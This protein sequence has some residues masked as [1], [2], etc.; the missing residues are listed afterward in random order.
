MKLPRIIDEW[1][2]VIKRA[3]DF[4]HIVGNA[5]S[6]SEILDCGANASRTPLISRTLII[7]FIQLTACIARRYARSSNTS[8]Y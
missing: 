1:H 5:T 3:R 4:S 6:M 2:Y 7:V 8:H